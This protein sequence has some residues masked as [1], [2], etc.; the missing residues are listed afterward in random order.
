MISSDEYLDNTEVNRPMYADQSDEVDSPYRNKLAEKVIERVAMEKRGK[1]QLLQDLDLMKDKFAEWENHMKSLDLQHDFRGAA[2]FLGQLVQQNYYN[3]LLIFSTMVDAH[4]SEGTAPKEMSNVREVVRLMSHQDDQKVT[5]TNGFH[6]NQ[7]VTSTARISLEETPYRPDY[8]NFFKCAQPI[9]DE[10]A[11]NPSEFTLLCGIYLTK[12]KNNYTYRKERRY[13]GSLP[14]RD[15]HYLDFKLI[16]IDRELRKYINSSLIG[17]D[18]QAKQYAHSRLHVEEK[19]YTSN[20]NL[21]NE[22]F[23]EKKI[24]NKQM[25]RSKMLKNALMILMSKNMLPT[26][27]VKLKALIMEFRDTV[28]WKIMLKMDEVE[29]MR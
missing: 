29:K 18:N 27:R 5:Y 26:D 10:E 2:E 28:Q 16:N 1:M 14:R 13:M 17:V 11:L 4:G 8:D 9:I 21:Y 25:I 22:V 6:V 24:F 20:L 15:Y 12:Y 23:Q 19:Q 3:L 7:A